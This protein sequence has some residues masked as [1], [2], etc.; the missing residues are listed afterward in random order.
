MRARFAILVPLALIALGGC[1][2][3]QCADKSTDAEASP[4]IFVN[5]SCPIG[6]EPV[7]ADGGVSVHN[8]EKVGFCCPG[9]KEEWEAMSA[10]DKDAF[11]A[12]AKAGNG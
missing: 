12:K 2:C 6:K 7:V 9:C 11:V 3:K 10:E 1:A 4:A 5:D 8:G